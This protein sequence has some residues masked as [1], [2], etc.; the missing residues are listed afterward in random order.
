MRLGI[1]L[2]HL[3]GILAGVEK[4]LV[5]VLFIALLPK[6]ELHYL[7]SG[8]VLNWKF[9]SFLGCSG[10]ALVIVFSLILEWSY[11]EGSAGS[12]LVLASIAA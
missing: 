10:Y 8:F 7:F 6:L 12:C 1:L 11:L 9:F 4:D 3:K 5:E 2:E